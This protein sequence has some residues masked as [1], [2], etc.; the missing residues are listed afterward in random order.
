MADPSPMKRSKAGSPVVLGANPAGTKPFSVSGPGLISR[1]WNFKQSDGS[2]LGPEQILNQSINQL[3][4]GMYMGWEALLAP[5][6][7]CLASL[8]A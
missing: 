6:T 8:Q 2:M 4:C 1:V 7:L 3:L 5:W